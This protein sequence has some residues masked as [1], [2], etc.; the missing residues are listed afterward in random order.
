[1][2][3]VRVEHGSRMGHRVLAL[4]I[5]GLA[6]GM[7]GCGNGSED[8]VLRV[9][10]N[11]EMTEVRIAFKRSGKLIERTVDEGDQV[12]QGQVIA[13]LDP[14]QL[15]Q[16]KN[17][18][19]ALLAAS[20]SGLRQLR[21]A[22]DFQRETIEGQ[23]AESQARLK[24]AEARLREL[25]AGSRRQEIGQAR[26]RVDVA[27]T[28]FTRAKADW[29]RA[30]TLYKA[31]DISRSQYDQFHAHFEAAKAQLQQAEEAFAL[32]KEGPRKERIASARA[33]VAQAEAAVRLAEAQRLEL[34]R[35]EQEVETRKADI[36]RAKAQVALVESQLEDMVARAPVSGIVLTKAAEV[37]EVLAAGTTVVTIGD[38][39]HPWLRGYINEEDLGR[40]KI[41]AKVRLTTDTFPGKSYPA[42]VSFIASEAEF[43]PKQIQT[44]EERVKLVYR[45][46][47]DAQNPNQEL[48]LNMPVDAD[49]EV[50]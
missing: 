19:E 4:F 41:G 33:A 13:R 14:E 15:L 2:K 32:V 20:T 9:S 18:A 6:A 40:V 10:G 44:T 27:R 1:M 35:R 29:D 26:A 46:K 42:R 47:I 17:Q 34:K 31:D 25:V 36:E 48:K 16:Q 39:E 37:G 12:K 11:I 43:T 21:T 45:I 49:I 24:Q 23:I 30:R 28:E 38:M 3:T 5:A 8:G 50:R 22:I 7:V